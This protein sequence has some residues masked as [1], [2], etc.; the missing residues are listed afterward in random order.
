MRGHDV[1]RPG[2]TMTRPAPRP[3]AAG[4]RARGPLLPGRARIAIALVLTLVVAAGWA[5]LGTSLLGLRTVE[6]RGTTTLTAAEVR[7]A[8]GVRTGFPLARVPLSS[9]QERVGDLPV[10]R[11]VHAARKWPHTLVVTVQ[12]REPV[13]VVADGGGWSYVDATGAAFAPAP[14]E[15]AKDPLGHPV[16]RTR[17]GDVAALRS[18][19]R[20][21]AALPDTL[22]G[23]VAHVDASTADSVTLVLRS[24]KS[25]VW[26][27]PDRSARKA[28][29]ATVLMKSVADGK[30]YD[31]SAPD[32]PT[33]R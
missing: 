15:E 9:V 17:K 30:T 16:L 33:V 27:S 5:V 7:R 3:R 6:V 1:S 22:L 11:T 10:V 25:V 19:A 8:A 24:G 29:V 32:A 28:T 18:A 14:A 20:V 26:G 13:G 4:P 12:D 23:S 2:A 31:V 21:V